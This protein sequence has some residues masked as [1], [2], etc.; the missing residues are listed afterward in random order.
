MLYKGPK[1]GIVQG[2]L[3]QAPRG[4]LQWFPQE[5]WS[6]EFNRAS[7]LGYDYIEFIA[8][9]QFNAKNPLWSQTGIKKIKD[10]AQKNHL[11]LH[12]FCD[13]HII[14]HSIIKN[15][16][17]LDRTHILI[18][19][20]RRLGIQKLVLP[21]FEESEINENNFKDYKDVLLDI[22]CAAQ[23][24]NIMV[25]L[26]TILNGTQL[27]KLL[28]FINHPN[29]KIVFDTGNRIA[30]GHNIYSDIVLL[31]DNIQHVHLKD[32]DMKNENVLIGTG[33]VNFY[34]VFESF[35][36]IGYKGPYTFETNR[37]R[38]AVKTAKFQIDFAD[39]YLKEALGYED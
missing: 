21:L 36:T 25:C 6:D 7:E 1:Y 15:R 8:E 33:S 5:N 14:D 2:R 39:F 10:L 13:D 35:L 37:G 3:S 26:E 11:S 32:K 18:S 20:G 31:G 28:E 34:T 30:F 16:K 24:D 38:N 4:I 17:V 27:L 19:Q 22:A 12:S 29:I 23:E 9:R